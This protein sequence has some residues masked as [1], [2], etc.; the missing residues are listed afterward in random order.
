MMGA[1]G[2]QGTESLLGLSDGSAA[3]NHGGLGMKV[4][5]ITEEGRAK[6]GRCSGFSQFPAFTSST[7]AML[8]VTLRVPAASHSIQMVPKTWMEGRL[9]EG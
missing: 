6:S 7:A 3:W 1:A 2:L 5:P 9:T 8:T 4:V